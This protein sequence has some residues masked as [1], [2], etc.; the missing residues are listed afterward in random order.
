M[1]SPRGT[2]RSLR[3]PEPEP[4]RRALAADGHVV[5]RQAHDAVP[6]QLEVSI[7]GGVALAVAVAA[8][9]VE[10]E[11]VELDGEPLRG[12]ERVDFVRG[13]LSLNCGIRLA[14]R[15]FRDRV[16]NAR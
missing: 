16:P 5:P 4:S 8:R 6:D 11:A 15:Q 3:T 2:L 12:P 14:A 13:L 1:S 9:T 10:L 7:A